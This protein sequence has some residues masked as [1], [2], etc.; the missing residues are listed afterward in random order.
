MRDLAAGSDKKLKKI[1]KQFREKF[2]FLNVFTRSVKEEHDP[3]GPDGPYQFVDRSVPVVVIKKWDGKTLKQQLGWAS[4]AGAKGL[5]RIVS[6]AIKDNGPVAP[7]K[8][9]RPLLKSMT[10]AKAAL[11]KKRTRSAIRDLKKI[12]KLGDDKKKFKDG[13]PS[14]AQE[15]AKLLDELLTEAN[16]EME[17]LADLATS[18]PKA[19]STGYIKLLNNYGELGD[20]KKRIKAARAA[21]ETK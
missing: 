5:S 8:A 18:D 17:R 3:R 12:V 1:S 16:K 19:A 9:L 11:G 7:P 13:A 15:A 20:L 14:V 10:K 4:S 21:L 2:I 6:K